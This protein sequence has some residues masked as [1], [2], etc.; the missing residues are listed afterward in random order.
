MDSRTVIKLLRDFNH[1]LAIKTLDKVIRDC[2]KMNNQ[3][4]MREIECVMKDFNTVCLIRDNM[5]VNLVYACI[6]L[7]NENISM[8]DKIYKLM[9]YN[10]LVL[11]NYAT[12]YCEKCFSTFRNIELFML[13]LN[14]FDEEAIRKNLS[15]YVRGD[16]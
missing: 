14:H 12:N 7:T 3:K 1:V 6:K 10:A 2:E 8:R 4:Y 5:H 9:E 13:L 15:K 11:S 16:E